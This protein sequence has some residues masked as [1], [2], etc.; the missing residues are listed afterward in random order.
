MNL[1][2][3][4]VAVTTGPGVTAV[5]PNQI[6]RGAT[7]TVTITGVGLTGATSL[8]FL[9]ATDGSVITSITASGILVNGAGTTLTANL[10]VTGSAVLGRRIIAINTPVGTTATLDTG[11]NTIE[12]IP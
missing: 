2:S 8:T 9:D 11:T 4:L 10:T 7:A 12:V 6:V 3:P 1:F 5:S